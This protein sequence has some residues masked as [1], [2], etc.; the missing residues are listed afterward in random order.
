MSALYFSLGAEELTFL[1]FWMFLTIAHSEKKCF[2]DKCDNYCHNNLKDKAKHIYICQMY[3]LS[4]SV[5]IK[6]SVFSM[7]HVVGVKQLSQRRCR[8]NTREMFIRS[9]GLSSYSP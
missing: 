8:N 5:C 6:A 1:P 2:E 7:V 9:V 4:V 3:Q